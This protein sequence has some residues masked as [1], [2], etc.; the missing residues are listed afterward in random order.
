MILKEGDK[1]PLFCLDWVDSNCNERKYCLEDLLKESEKWII[2]YFYPKDNTP[3][4]TKEAIEFTKL[5]EDFKK[6]WYIVVWVSKDSIKSHCNFIQKK[7]LNLILLSDTNG[8]VLEKYW[9]WW[10]KKMY[11]RI[12]KWVIRSTFVIDKDGK[13]KRVYYNVRASWHAERVLNEIRNL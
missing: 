8:E 13:I 5:L 3:W 2:L 1:A 10:E 4:C 11:W 6:E 9:A 12:T 7:D